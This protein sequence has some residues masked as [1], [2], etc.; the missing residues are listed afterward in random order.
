MSTRNRLSNCHNRFQ[1][2]A[3]RVLTVCSAGLLRSPTAA[4]VLSN[5]PWN[6]NCRAAGYND[7]YALVLVDQVLLEWASDVVCMDAVQ[8]Y[9]LHRQ[10]EQYQMDRPVYNLEVPD[11]YDYRQP[12]L[13]NLMTSKFLELYPVDKSSNW[14]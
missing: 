14:L 13:V 9:H 8:E 6:F 12:E 4:W 2:S 1:G 7:E 11:E 10:L 5:D 3:K